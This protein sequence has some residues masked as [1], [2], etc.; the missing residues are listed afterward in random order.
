MLEQKFTI[1]K[2]FTDNAVIQCNKPFFLWGCASSNSVIFVSIYDSQN[3]LVKQAKTVTNKKGCWRVR[4]SPMKPSLENHTIQFTCNSKGGDLCLH[5]ELKNILFGDV[6]LCVGQSNMAMNY[7]EVPNALSNPYTLK[8]SH[9]IENYSSANIRLIKLQ[10]P[11][12]KKNNRIEAPIESWCN[13]KPEYSKNFSSLAFFFG[14]KLQENLGNTPIGLID[15][16]ES[17][18]MIE[19]WMSM[20]TYNQIVARH[21]LKKIAYP[22]ISNC[23]NTMISHI[24]SLSI[25][26]IVWYQGC[27]NTYSDD[28][29]NYYP[30]LL[31]G[32]ISEWR[33]IFN[34][35]IFK[36]TIPFYIVQLS[37][38]GKRE[39]A[40]NNE[41]YFAQQRW[42]QT[43]VSESIKNSGIVVTLDLGDSGDIA[44]VHPINKYDVADR[45]ANM[46]LSKT[47]GLSLAKGVYSPLPIKARRKRR[48]LIVK[49]KYTKNLKVGDGTMLRGFIIA[50]GNKLFE[51]ADAYIKADSVV[52]CPL[53][54][55]RIETPKFVRYAWSKNPNVNL[56]N[57]SGLP[58]GSFE[59]SI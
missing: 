59:I 10:S 19:Q 45:L 27:S 49:F 23:F 18:S 42:N 35:Y 48:A 57:D 12:D 22:V 33:K 5:Q 52:V 16:S 21:N 26:G 47:Y 2:I 40:L 24:K 36:K 6:W 1:A 58:C 8:N 51:Y 38:S 37:T 43:L 20:S 15:A 54:D 44:D 55:S 41:C 4:F 14:K 39:N 46:V 53:P 13:C 50:G 56:V 31:K 30:I 32:L 7:H 29:V 28:A 34:P 9:I 11:L 25:K 3:K 17:G